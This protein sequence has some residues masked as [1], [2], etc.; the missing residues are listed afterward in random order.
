[1][2][3]AIASVS[4][5]LFVIGFVPYIIAIMYGVSLSKP[6]SPLAR[7]YSQLCRIPRF[8]TCFE[9]KEPIKPSKVTWTIWTALDTITFV[10]MFKENTL[11]WQIAGAVLGAWTVLALV[12]KYGTWEWT[13]I[14]A[15]CLLGA[16]LA[17]TLWKIF[18]DATVGIV[19][20]NTVVF[21]GSTPMFDSAWETPTNESKLAWTIWWISCLLAVATIP[22]WTLA[23][24]FQPITFCAIETVM[25]YIVYVRAASI[26][27]TA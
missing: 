25:V 13:R 2:H 16:V 17:V 23:D 18:G 4:G 14:D 6:T 20:S 7:L 21:L 27:K 8:R 3:N 24:T 9:P 22:A 5:I 11:N 19:V 12:L 1:M 10:G 15:L 26:A